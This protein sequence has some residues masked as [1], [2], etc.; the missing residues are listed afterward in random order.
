M[1]AL[2]VGNTLEWKIFK[3]INKSDMFLKMLSGCLCV[4][5]FLYGILMYF[6]C[7]IQWTQ[8]W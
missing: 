5:D 8:W 4:L 1:H 2:H 7:M 6:S 3:L